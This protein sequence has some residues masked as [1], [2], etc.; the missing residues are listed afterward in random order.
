MG[1]IFDYIL[2]TRDFQRHFIGRYKDEEAYS[3][4]DSG[5]VDET[6]P[7]TPDVAMKTVYWKVRAFMGCNSGQCENFAGC[8]CMVG[9]S[10]CFNRVNAFLY[11]IEYANT[12]G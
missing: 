7:Y 10:Q 3:Y 12:H 9:A 1:H 4:F 5:F 2:K 8:T 6:L 11:K